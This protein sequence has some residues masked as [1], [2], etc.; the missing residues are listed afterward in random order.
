[1]LFSKPIIIVIIIITIIISKKN[2]GT[3]LINVGAILYGADMKWGRFCLILQI[4]T[5]ISRRNR[6]CNQI[7][8]GFFQRLIDLSS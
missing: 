7:F 8:L 5:D 6:E 3:I 1:M 4:L 2:V